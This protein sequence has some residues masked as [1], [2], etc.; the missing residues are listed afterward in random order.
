L[1]WNYGL[2]N[3]ADNAM[4]EIKVFGIEMTYI[5][6]GSFYAGDNGTMEAALPKRFK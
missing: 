4:V 1:K 2:D 3:V 6:Q 5:P